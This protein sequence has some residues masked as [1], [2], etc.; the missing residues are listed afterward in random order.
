MTI[1]VL[2]LVGSIG[3]GKSD[4]SFHVFSRLFRTGTPVARLDLDDVGMCHPAPADDPENHRVKS[5][6]MG[7][8]WSVFE[9]H[10]ATCFVIS[11]GVSTPSEVALYTGCLP[12]ADW[13]I[14]RIRIGA[15]ERRDRTIRRGRKLGQDAR[16]VEQ[17]IQ[18][19]IDEE[20]SLDTHGFAKHVIDT[21]GLDQQQVVDVV[22]QQA[23][24]PTPTP[25]SRSG[26]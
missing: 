13:T 26:S 17:W 5:E 21:D 18:T 6:A 14:V 12:N 3:T 9:Q 24:W 22:L 4:T 16:T 15:D 23:G 20:A 25:L 1:P 8:A 2:W 19:G 11:G 10:G 7:A